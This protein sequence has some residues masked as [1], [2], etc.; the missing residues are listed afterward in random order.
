M[1]THGRR[2]QPGRT[3]LILVIGAAVLLAAL[4]TAAVRLPDRAPA[5]LVGAFVADLTLLVG[6]FL[7]ERRH[8]W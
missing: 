5:I 2:T 3:V 6:L 7:F 1:Q 4:G 8:H